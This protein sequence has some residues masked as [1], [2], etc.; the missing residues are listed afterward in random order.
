MTI[1]VLSLLFFCENKLADLEDQPDTRGRLIIWES[2]W[3][4]DAFYVT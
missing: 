2:G 3:I 1:P 4:C